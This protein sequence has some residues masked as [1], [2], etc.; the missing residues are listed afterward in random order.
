MNVWKNSGSV[1]ATSLPLG[2]GNTSTTTSGVG[3]LFTC[4]AGNSSLGGAQVV[5]PWITGSTWNSTTKV[6]VAGS[7]SW[8]QAAFTSSLSSSTRL[9]TTNNLPKNGLTGTFP[10]AST[11]PA[12][13]YDRNPNSIGS[14]TTSTIRITTTPTVSST[15]KCLGNG[16]IG[17]MLNGVTLYNSLDGPG[18][19]AVA[20]ESQ[21]LC[22]GHPESNSQYHYHN[23]S[24]CL[25]SKVTSN[26]EVV[27]WAYDG[28]PI[29]VERDAA[30]NLPNNADLDACHGRTSPITVD[31]KVV[32]QYHYSAT[33]EFPYTLGC[34]R[35]TNSV[36]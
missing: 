26:S 28:Y 15:P 13:A 18:R 6:V 29:V 27:G 32:T 7:K 8:P 14:S 22:Q 1:V 31:G 36:R 25:S 23:V 4:T 34:F 16:A 12:Y 3:T 9:F 35:G 21:D 19:D 24:T 10:I 11:D 2:D 5:G 17:I 20:N 33:L 30:G